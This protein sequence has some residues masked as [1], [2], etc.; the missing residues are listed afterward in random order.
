MHVVDAPVLVDYNVCDGHGRPLSL[1]PA[2]LRIK[3]RRET[4]VHW[5]LP[6][7]ESLMWIC[8]VDRGS[9]WSRT[10][11]KTVMVERAS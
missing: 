8:G 4:I 1:S 9:K 10:K 7:F 11:I 6:S 3:R 2:K 5:P